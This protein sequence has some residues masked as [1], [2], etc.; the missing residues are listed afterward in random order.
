[1]AYHAV[2]VAAVAEALL[3]SRL[4]TAAVGAE[5]LGVSPDLLIPF[6]VR[7]IALHDL[8]K[9]AEGFQQRAA[10]LGIAPPVEGSA[11]RCEPHTNAGLSLWFDRLGERLSPKLCTLPFP[12]TSPL[13]LAVFA[14][15]GRPGR[16]SPTPSRLLFREEEVALAEALAHDLCALWQAAPTLID[17]PPALLRRASWWLAGLTT[18]SDW[19][20]SNPTWFPYVSPTL[21]LVTYL[22]TAARHRASTAL[23]HAGLRAPRSASLSSFAALTARPDRVTLD[24]TPAQ[25]WAGSVELPT[26]GP[27]FAIIEDVTGSGKTE[28]AQMIAH[29]LMA[30]G[31]A[32]GV[33]WAMPTMAT[34]NAMYLRQVPTLSRLYDPTG[35]VPSLILAHGQAQ[36]DDRFRA[37]LLPL[38]PAS[39]SELR[40]EEQTSTAAC[41]AWLAHDRR[42]AFLADV[43]AGTIDQALLAALPSRFNTLRLLGLAD[44]VIVF[45]EVH[46]YD[47][48][49]SAELAALVSFLGA[50]GAS[51]VMLSAT[52]PLDCR[53]KF[54]AAWR[55]GLALQPPAFL[56]P[57]SVH[58]PAYPAT[59]F[60]T[61]D[62]ETTHVAVTASSRSERTTPV[63][64]IHDERDALAYLAA[65]LQHGAAAA[66]VRNTVTDCLR[67]AAL[68]RELGL[69]P[70]VFHARFAQCDRQRIEAEV[71][72]RL[73][74][75]ARAAERSRVLVIATQ[76][77][78]QSLDLDFD[79]MVSDLAPIDL[80]LQRA[81][82]LWRHHRVRPV[83]IA[84][85]LLVLEPP[86][87]AEDPAGW[88]RRLGGSGRVY[89][90]DMLW[91]TAEVLS[92]SASLVVPHGVRDAVERVYGRDSDLEVPQELRDAETTS[93]GKAAADAQLATQNVLTVDSGYDGGRLSFDDE[94]RVPTRLGEA[95]VTLRLAKAGTGGSLEPWCDDPSKPESDRWLLSEL[96]VRATLVHPAA[97]AANAAPEA[98]SRAAEAWGAHDR[99]CVLAPIAPS[100]GGGAI[101][102]RFPGERVVQF[103]YS[104]AEGLNRA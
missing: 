103:L 2:D 37:S 5:L 56:A 88:L 57:P 71:L 54:I 43:G 18:L 3:T 17:R 96:R 87:R 82:R 64:V 22:E 27:L 51:V 24:P 42:V 6:V 50:M 38:M 13:A 77:I 84:H 7:W 59:T 91:R 52:L 86:D 47:A 102:L 69:T 39:R 67:A 62:G 97:T 26:A 25:L 11:L 35:P 75:S 10:H 41:A 92:S 85:E 32:S 23:A 45:D 66:W 79:V 68:A 100:A 89:R 16:L 58:D 31:R 65:A 73:G 94:E 99:D 55:H 61:P 12:R 44:K 34:A 83:A 36:I 8:G 90:P 15:H 49:M 70:L 28:A 29:R 63:R 81:G 20:G 30:A 1:L 95:T 101:H 78:E 76:V 19:I 9:C 72:R 40:D 80:L 48:Y 33:Y 74:P 60:I 14:H 21:D 104:E 53:A 93:A 4:R 46:A 98:V